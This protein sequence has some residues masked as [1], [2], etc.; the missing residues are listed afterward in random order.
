MGR[1]PN[2]LP[3]P[4]FLRTRAAS[5]DVRVMVWGDGALC[6]PKRLNEAKH[7]VKPQKGY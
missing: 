1:A 6:W 5:V 2:V 3:G 7:T 4:H